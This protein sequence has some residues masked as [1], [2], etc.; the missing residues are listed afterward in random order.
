MKKCIKL[1]I[2]KNLN[3]NPHCTAARTSNLKCI[4]FQKYVIGFF[5]CCTV[6]FDNTEILITKKCTP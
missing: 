3:T 1:V 5:Y 2:S 4:S 6:H